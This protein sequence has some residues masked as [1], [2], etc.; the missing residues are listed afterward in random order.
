[1]LNDNW[2]AD[3]QSP[4]VQTV[5]SNFSIHKKSD[6]EWYSPS[7]LSHPNGYEMCLRIIANGQ[8]E[9][10][11]THLSLYIHLMA[12]KNDDNLS[13]PFRGEVKV[14]LINHKGNNVELSIFF[15]DFFG[16][17]A[18]NRVING[19]P[20]NGGLVNRVGQG[21]ALFISH[22]KLQGSEFLRDD[23]IRVVIKEII[24]YAAPLPEIAPSAVLDFVIT[25]FSKCK[26][27][28]EECISQ[29]FYSH[30]YGY[31]L[32]LLVY[33]NGRDKWKNKYI[34]I[35]VHLMKGENDDKLTFPF[36]GDILVQIVNWRENKRHVEQLIEFNKE[37]DPRGDYGARVTGL[38]GFL[39]G[40][41]YR[42]Y[43]F[44]DFLSHEFL[45]FDESRNT[46]YVND[47]DSIHVRVTKITL[48]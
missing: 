45:E 42:G 28:N 25:N 8:Y 46:Q 6:K 15:H 7:F 2:N 43:G 4:P 38:A 13:W 44:P 11:G 3:L 48:A 16:N 12:G 26:R 19:I 39:S 32:S 31:K 17:Q 40:R 27:S 21:R 36:R 9:G 22:D 20:V 33:P 47:D 24:V 23:S 1:M 37:T 35:F 30:E 29:S 18:C 41:Q 10:Y 34:S 5:M 14:Q